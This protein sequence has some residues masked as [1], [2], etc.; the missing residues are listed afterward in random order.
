MTAAISV[1]LVCGF[2]GAGKSSVIRHLARARPKGDI[3]GVIGPADAI[4]PEAGLFHQP[5]PHGCPCCVGSVTFHARLVQ[6]IRRVGAASLKHILVEGGPDGHAA[7][8]RAQIARGTTGALLQVNEVIAVIDPR[9]VELPLPAARSALEALVRDADTV[10]ASK[11]DRAGADT[12]SSFADWMQSMNRA[13]I[14]ATGGVPIGC[15]QGG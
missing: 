5:V 13:W 7:A 3:W 2:R 11:W 12:R 14:P 6:L 10:V 4:E 9:W 1:V 8:T 15:G